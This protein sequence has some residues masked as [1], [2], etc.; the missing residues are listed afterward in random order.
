MIT[1]IIGIKQE[2]DHIGIERLEFN[3]MLFM[4]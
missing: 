2:A 1:E 4:L 3:F